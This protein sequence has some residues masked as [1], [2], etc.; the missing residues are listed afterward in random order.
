MKARQRS[1]SPTAIFWKN[2]VASFL[3]GGIIWAAS[4]MISGFI[5]PW[6]ADSPYYFVSLAGSGLVL[7]VWSP[8]KIWVHYLGAMLGQLAYLLVFIDA[9]PF[10]LLGVLFLMGYTFLVLIGAF[11]GSRVWNMRSNNDEKKIGT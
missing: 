1:I 7:G 6:D 9:S 5:E 11:I 8:V 3:I 10:F 4:P 2:F